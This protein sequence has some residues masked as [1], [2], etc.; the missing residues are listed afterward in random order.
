M[1]SSAAS[2]WP[3]LSDLDLRPT[4]E[5]LHLW[6]Q[7]VGK[8]RLMTTPWMNHSWHVP[9]YLSVRGLSTGLMPAG[10]R[11]LTIEL[12][13]V[14][15]ALTIRDTEAQ[16]QVIP[17]R[18]QSVAAF[19]AAVMSALRSL[20][21]EVRVDAMPCE[22]P[23]AIPFHRDSQIRNYDGHVARTYWRAL[24]QVQRV[25]ELFRTRFVGKCSPI[26]L[27]WGSFDLAVTRFSGRAAPPHPGGAP[28]LP[29]SVARDAYNQ[30]VSSA[31]FWPGSGAVKSPSFYSYA[32]PGPAGF[33]QVVPRPAAARFDAG[34]GEFLL[35]YDDVRASADPDEALLEF[36]QS[37]YEAAADLGH[38]NRAVLER[39]T[40]PIGHPP[41]G[42]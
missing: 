25:F 37:T 16:E 7:V 42:A 1:T 39:S 4:M 36:L 32:Y 12:D 34:F 19:Y 14:G 8:I 2:A 11:A 5:A 9:L 40:G 24:L 27:F 29:D 18:P 26:H 38:W 23:E 33:A 20:G 15:D 13:L 28:N 3:D 41:E 10:R 6:C 17:L 30:E 21:I 31:G 35:A 22:L